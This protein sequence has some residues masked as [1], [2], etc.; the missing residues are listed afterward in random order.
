M[1][2][3][4]SNII[5]NTHTEVATIMFR[6][7]GNKATGQ[8]IYTAISIAF[9]KRKLERGEEVDE[10]TR[11]MYVGQTDLDTRNEQDGEANRAPPIG[12]EVR[13]NPYHV[14]E[15]QMQ[16]R[17]TCIVEIGTL[18][19]TMREI[20][21]KRPI[22]QVM[23]IDEMFDLFTNGK[24]E[25]DKTT[26]EEDAE[27]SGLTVEEIFEAQRQR[28]VRRANS[29]KEIQAEAKLMVDG[30]TDSYNISILSDLSAVDQHQYGVRCYEKLHAELLRMT[31][32]SPR[33][34]RP[35]HAGLMTLIRKTKE[36]L[37]NWL[38]Q[39]EDDPQFTQE[40][41]DASDRNPNMVFSY[42]LQPT[43]GKTVAELKAAAS[44]KAA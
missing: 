34:R 38:I 14:L 12:L 33:Q 15:R 20:G 7:I 22:G 2:K 36:D 18:T 41:Q 25:V 27:I 13:I 23:D 5:D 30:Y 16:V 17:N 44:L 10:P 40:F 19:N 31:S 11:T 21:S 6:A 8:A 26:A 24:A 39:V 43:L 42:N 28:A 3:T 32:L 35:E 1:K 9:N 29:L 4:L 37:L